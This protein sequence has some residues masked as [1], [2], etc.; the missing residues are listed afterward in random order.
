[1]AWQ[2][3]TKA[4]IQCR[5]PCLAIQFSF[6]IFCRKTSLQM[7]RPL[8]YRGSS[9][10]QACR[11][12]QANLRFNLSRPIFYRKARRHYAK[13][14]WSLRK[15]TMTWGRKILSSSVSWR[16]RMILPHHHHHHHHHRRR[17]LEY[18][19]MG[20]PLGLCQAWGRCPGI[21]SPSL[22]LP[23]PILVRSLAISWSSWIKV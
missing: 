12:D 11:T 15:K 4:W 1:M 5:W 17:R 23:L 14:Y 3:D 18:T 9:R 21:V 19:G 2:K 20:T 22:L 13:R 7:G 10:S 6:K 8:H 16:R